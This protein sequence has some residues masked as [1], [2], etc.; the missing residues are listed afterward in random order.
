MDKIIKHNADTIKYSSPKQYGDFREIEHVHLTTNDVYSIDGIIKLF[1]DI[2][3]TVIREEYDEDDSRHFYIK[4]VGI[5][6]TKYGLDLSENINTFMRN[7]STLVINSDSQ[8]NEWVNDHLGDLKSYL[9]SDSSVIQSFN[10]LENYNR[11]VD[12]QFPPIPM[13]DRKIES[14][15]EPNAPSQDMNG[16][17]VSLKPPKVVYDITYVCNQEP[18]KL[19]L[20]PLR[21]LQLIFKD[22]PFTPKEMSSRM[23]FFFSNFDIEIHTFFEIGGR[24]FSLTTSG[25]II[26]NGQ[27]V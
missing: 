14:K 21:V 6:Y 2:I 25:S 17:L 7:S 24:S 4:T 11:I 1:K 26:D 22:A 8:F 12:Q 16:Q 27:I 5:E 19:T 15:L 13:Y 20:D 18:E 10:K 23:K 9:P 3:P